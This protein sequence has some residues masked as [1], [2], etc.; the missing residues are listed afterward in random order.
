MFIWYIITLILFFNLF[1]K[2]KN[3]LSNCH[4][5]K[6]YSNIIIIIMNKTNW[7]IKEYDADLITTICYTW[8][9]KCPE[10]EQQLVRKGSEWAVVR[11]KAR[12]GLE[13]EFFESFETVDKEI[14]ETAPKD[15]ILFSRYVTAHKWAKYPDMYKRLNAFS[16][17]KDFYE[18]DP[19][20]FDANVY[21][22][23]A[24]AN[25]YIFAEQ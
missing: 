6:Q 24:I 25:A 20:L 7:L 2:L 10:M 14:F 19:E 13:D 12:A 3:V 5:D 16:Q 22:L 8:A 23:E 11:Q 1:K 15:C 17:F 18:T 9:K 21:S 4:N